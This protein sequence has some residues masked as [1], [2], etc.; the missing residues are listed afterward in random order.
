VL[1]WVRDRT[2]DGL[3]SEQVVRASVAGELGWPRPGAA[4]SDG[5][6]ASCRAAIAA[7]ERVGAKWPT[8]TASSAAPPAT[9]TASKLLSELGRV[10]R[11]A[12]ARNVRF[13]SREVLN[14]ATTVEALDVVE[15]TNGVEDHEAT[16]A[17]WQHLDYLRELSTQAQA[18]VALQ[19]GEQRV[20]ET[21]RLL[22]VRA[23]DPSS[24]PHERATARRLLEL[25]ERQAAT[26]RLNG[27][28]A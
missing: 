10:A 27:G 12:R 9:R 8:A 20:T 4:L 6:L 13:A 3:T 21:L 26:P 2:R 7:L 24:S 11:D 16:I 17:L 25:R 28:P 23:A 15:Y 14:A 18:L 22:R 5:T 1:D 19:I